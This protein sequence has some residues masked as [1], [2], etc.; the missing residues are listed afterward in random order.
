MDFVYLY[1]KKIKL[2]NINFT[3]IFSVEMNIQKFNNTRCSR[4]QMG[5]T[6]DHCIHIFIT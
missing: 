2:N 3:Y 4:D 1:L 6:L 5:Q